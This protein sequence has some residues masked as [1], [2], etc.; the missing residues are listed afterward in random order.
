MNIDAST[1]DMDELGWELSK[2]DAQALKTV[3]KALAWLVEPTTPQVV[4]VRNDE[5][6]L[7]ALV[8][9]KRNGEYATQFSQLLMVY[10]YKP[11]SE[12][13][14]HLKARSDR[15]AAEYTINEYCTFDRDLYRHLADRTVNCSG[16]SIAEVADQVSAILFDPDHSI[17]TD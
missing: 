4:A 11:I 8:S 17:G 15:K 9:A 1:A 2:D 6:M 10:L 14:E 3:N 13:E 5:M 12:L 16:K 7:K